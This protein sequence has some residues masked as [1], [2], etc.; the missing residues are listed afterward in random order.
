MKRNGLLWLLMLALL[1]PVLALSSCDKK[2]HH[3]DNDDDESTEKSEKKKKNDIA[4]EYE[5]DKESVMMLL[6]DNADSFGDDSD[7]SC[8]LNMDDDKK[9]KLVFNINASMYIPD[10][11]NTMRISIDIIGRGSWKY[12]K[13]DKLLSMDIT[14]A[15]IDYFDLS[16]DDQNEKTDA[17]LA[18]LGGMDAFKEQMKE[19]FNPDDLCEKKEFKITELTDDGFYARTISGEIKKVKFNRVD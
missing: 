13:K 19:G 6:G 12:D 4:G 9:L 10:I 3:Y 2:K 8:V 1:V 14:R 11:E 15:D 7:V 18:E 17:V 16:F 5:M